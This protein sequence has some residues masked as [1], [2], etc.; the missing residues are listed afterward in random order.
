M[1]A[2]ASAPPPCSGA[3][4]TFRYQASVW[5]AGW[6]SN[7]ALGQNASQYATYAATAT[8][9]LFQTYNTVPG[10]SV[11]LVM[12]GVDAGGSYSGVGS[13]SP[14]DLDVGY[15][16]SLRALFATPPT[17][18]PTAQTGLPATWWSGNSYLAYTRPLTASLS[19]WYNSAAGGA[20]YETYCNFQGVNIGEFCVTLVWAVRLM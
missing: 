16:S 12:T 1:T 4:S 20:G 9:A 8:E 14:L 3:F 17:V 10:A 19:S 5:T 11:R 6:D 2:I 13:G 15:F 7:Q 18:Y